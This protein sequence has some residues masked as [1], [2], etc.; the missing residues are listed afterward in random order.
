MP[1]SVYAGEDVVLQGQLL[2]ADSNDSRVS[3]RWRF[4]DKVQGDSARIADP[5]RLRTLIRFPAIPSYSL[6]LA[7]TFGAF[8]VRDTLLIKV[9]PPLS[10][11]MMKFLS[12]QPGDTLVQNQIHKVTWAYAATDL[13]RLEVSYKD[14]S[15]D[16]IADSVVNASGQQGG[17][18]WTPPAI[19]G[20]IYSCL[21][22]LKAIP[23]DS[24]LG[25]MSAH[26][27]LVP[28]P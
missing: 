1:Q 13:V 20:T 10:P 25:V 14:G 22:R 12:P 16:M 28:A 18:A 3:I 11:T 27:I 4:L 17:Y 2:G 21:L 9:L 5:T 8:T 23:S 26:F 19:G 7:A 15:W 24:I 6:E